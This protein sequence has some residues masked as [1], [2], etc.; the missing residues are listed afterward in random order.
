MMLEET[1]DLSDE[2]NKYAQILEKWW[3]TQIEIAWLKHNAHYK[4]LRDLNFLSSFEGI[5][6]VEEWNEHIFA[7]HSQRT[8][9]K[10]ISKKIEQVLWVEWTS[11]SNRVVSRILQ[12]VFHYLEHKLFLKELDRE[13]TNQVIFY[14]HKTLVEKFNY[15]YK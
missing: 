1:I 7:P 11:I 9:E 2:L 13:Q 6:M 10:F 8:I 12:D 5:L 14:F 15:T 3:L 4:S